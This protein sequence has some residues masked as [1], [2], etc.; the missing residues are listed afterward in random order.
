MK[1]LYSV[2]VILGA[3]S[4]PKA[5]ACV[6]INDKFCAEMVE[7]H[8]NCIESEKGK[9]CSI[10]AEVTEPKRFYAQTGAD[11]HLQ[12]KTTENGDQ[13]ISDLNN[14]CM[15]LGYDEANVGAG[16]VLENVKQTPAKSITVKNKRHTNK[17]VRLFRI[18]P[19]VSITSGNKT[20]SSW[21]SENGKSQWTTA[22]SK[23][24]LVVKSVKCIVH[25][26]TVEQKKAD[27]FWSR[28]M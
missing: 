18:Q 22:G 8:E 21:G 2:L 12:I 7:S 20:I 25:D 26:M 6:I 23:N 15:D 9:S 28:H 13:I 10:M 3:F 16:F 14:V 17:S 1:Y 5:Q 4:A 19:S 27:K 11:V 24:S